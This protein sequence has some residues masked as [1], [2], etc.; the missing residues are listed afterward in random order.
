M[1]NAGRPTCATCPWWDAPKTQPGNLPRGACRQG[2]PTPVVLYDG[3]KDHVTTT[4]PR[5]RDIE[6]CSLHPDMP[7]W[8]KARADA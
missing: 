6:W 5:T 3:A 7:A 2:R 4:W 1:A 8:F